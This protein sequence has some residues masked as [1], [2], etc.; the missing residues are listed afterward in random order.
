LRPNCRR[1][2]H[3]GNQ[4]PLRYNATTE[5]HYVAI[6]PMLSPGSTT[7]GKD[8]FP[9]PFRHGARSHC[10]GPLR[11]QHFRW[12]H[13]ANQNTG[14]VQAAQ[15]SLPKYYHYYSIPVLGT[16]AGYAAL[17]ATGYYPKIDTPTG[18]MAAI[19][20]I[21]GIDGLSSHRRAR[22]G[23]RLVARPSL[24]SIFEGLSPSLG[25]NAQMAGLVTTVGG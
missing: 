21:D 4:E 25:S 22:L 18:P 11:D 5:S 8:A 23:G 7:P 10:D 24:V 17:S 12:I 20:Y 14:H 6:S 9:S 16:L 15:W 2:G 3:A 19:L 1:T 13:R